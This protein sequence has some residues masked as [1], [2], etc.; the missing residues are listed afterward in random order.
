MFP[1]WQKWGPPRIGKMALIPVPKLKTTKK[2]LVFSARCLWSH[3]ALTFR[4][5][6][7][8]FHAINAF[9]HLFQKQKTPR[10]S[11]K[12][13]ELP[14]DKTN[15]MACAPSEDSDQPGHPPS[16][17]RVFAVCMK[18][19]WVLSYPLNAQ[20]RLWSDWVNAQADPSLCWAH[21]HFVGFVMRR[22]ISLC[23]TCP[24]T[25]VRGI[26]RKRWKMLIWKKNAN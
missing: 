22:L 14:N 19:A 15:K 17:I 16:L 12:Y 20:Q 26:F 3:L 2:K 6:F 1:T 23:H 7:P 21:S 25:N 13:F 8:C 18:K 11:S 5:W 4:H 24:R 9:T 10:R